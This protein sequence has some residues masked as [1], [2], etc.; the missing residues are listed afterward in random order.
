[1]YKYEL[2]CHTSEVSAC[3]HVPAEKVVEYYASQNYTGI[4]ITDHFV[5]G[6]GIPGG[7]E[8]EKWIDK[9][10]SGYE[11]AKSAGDKT[12]LKVFFGFEYTCYSNNGT[13][14]LIYGLGK[15]WLKSHPEIMDMGLRQGLEFM[16]CE[17]A[18][19]V[20]AHPYRESSYIE[21]IRL[22]PRHIH[23]VEVKNANRDDTENG[24]AEMYSKYYG[25]YRL[26]GTDN[27][28][29][30]QQKRFCGIKTELEINNPSNLRKIAES[31]NYTL[32][33]EMR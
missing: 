6:R 3:A 16:M 22:L 14:F 25:L 29:G 24:A 28:Q 17:G 7:L 19:I 32:F 10:C 2:H 20:H 11:T 23:A 27:H 13:D 26:A 30:G 9:F 5:C 8:W 15:E 12:G 18:F 1:M 33:D 21:M 31:G 4:F